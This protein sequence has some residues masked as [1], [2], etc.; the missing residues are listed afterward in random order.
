MGGAGMPHNLTINGV[1]HT[2][3][4]SGGSQPGMDQVVGIVSFAIVNQQYEQQPFTVMGSGG[5]YAVP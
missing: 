5:N 1:G 3:L 4:W 2:I